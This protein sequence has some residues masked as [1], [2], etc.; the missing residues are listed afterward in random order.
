MKALAVGYVTTIGR[1]TF[2]SMLR[3]CAKPAKELEAKFSFT[4]LTPR[5]RHFLQQ[6]AFFSVLKGGTLRFS[7]ARWKK[8]D[9]DQAK[10]EAARMAKRFG[11]T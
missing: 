1:T 4:K 10:K 6:G 2:W 9:I 5:E 8:R 7:R 11:W 3:T